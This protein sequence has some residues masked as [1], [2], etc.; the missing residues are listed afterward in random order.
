MTCHTGIIATV[1][2][3]CITSFENIFMQI[4]DC[5][6]YRNSLSVDDD[7]DMTVTH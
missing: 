4:I 1:Q 2:S 5:V 7:T 6:K 3:L